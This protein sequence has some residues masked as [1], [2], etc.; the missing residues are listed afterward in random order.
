MDGNKAVGSK[1]AGRR[2]AGSK[3]ATGLAPD[4]LGY[5]EDRDTISLAGA[6]ERIRAP[7]RGDGAE[8]CM[9][10]LPPAMDPVVTPEA[11]AEAAEK[12]V[13]EV[14]VVE[15]V[16]VVAAANSP[17][18]S[19]SRLP[20]MPRPIRTSIRGVMS[21]ATAGIPAADSKRPTATRSCSRRIFC[22]L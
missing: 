18:R 7:A 3:T 4:K 22:V 10:P 9:K 1:V 15:V 20:P 5:K 8:S 19:P 12:E 17:S 11:A 6:D 13:E 16:E 21:E 2:V 14:E